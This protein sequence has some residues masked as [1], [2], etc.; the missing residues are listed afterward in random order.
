[1]AQKTLQMRYAQVM[2]VDSL[3][4]AAKKRA[5]VPP[6]SLRNCLSFRVDR[7][8]GGRTHTHSCF[9]YTAGT[10]RFNSTVT[11]RNST[12]T[13][14]SMIVTCD[15]LTCDSKMVFTG[16]IAH[17]PTQYVW[18]VGSE[19]HADT[20]TLDTSTFVN[21]FDHHAPHVHPPHSATLIS[22]TYPAADKDY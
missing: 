9:Y 11:G 8:P 18:P 16:Q 14:G 4:D 3:G 7:L 13:N 1:M 15:L 2:L 10:V 19:P 5:S 22:T 17:R 21:R 12:N 6:S 20:A